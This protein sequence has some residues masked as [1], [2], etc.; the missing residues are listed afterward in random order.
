MKNRLSDLNNH[1]FAQMERLSNEKLDSENLKKELERSKAVSA[2][3][4]D[5]VATGQ[6]TLKAQALIWD[7]VIDNKEVPRLLQNAQADEA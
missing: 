6:L 3:A 4:K 2:I 1:L 5:I 7:R